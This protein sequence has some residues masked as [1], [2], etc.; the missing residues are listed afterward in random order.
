[1]TIESM[2]SNHRI[3]RLDEDGHTDH[4]HIG[5][6]KADLVRGWFSCGDLQGWNNNR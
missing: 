6:E 2:D 4:D 3:T 5:L 1:M